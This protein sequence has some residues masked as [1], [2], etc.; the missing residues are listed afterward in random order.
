MTP[1]EKLFDEVLSNALDVLRLGARKRAETLRRLKALEKAL[2][3]KLA[4][5]TVKR[6]ERRKLAT[7]LKNS[8]EII[9]EHFSQIQLQ[10][11]LGDVAKTV[12]EITANTLVIALGEDAAGLPT[13]DYFK[14]VASQ[15]MIQGSP[16]E[17]WWSR[18]AEATRLAFEQQIRQGL[19]SAETNQKIISRIVGSNG[20]GGLM[21]QARYQ[22]S[23]LVQSSVQAVA[24]DARRETFRKNSD[25]IEGLRQVS[26]LDSHTSEICIAYGT[27]GA[28]HRGG[29]WDFEGKPILGTRLP[30]NGGTP[31]HF[32]CRSVEVPILKTFKDLGVNIP[33][34]PVGT[35]ASD[36]GQISR[37]TTFDEFLKRKGQAYQDEVL[38]E[39]KADLWRAGK[40][41]L[42][43]LVSGDGKPLTLTQLRQKAGLD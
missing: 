9:K 16:V 17:S 42:R 14:A 13:E 8:A 39:G 20:V 11:E 3:E 15:A 33:E 36:E 25:I 31:R 2:V 10:L 43:D 40:I 38:G 21:G 32:G 1:D 24:N 28:D 41:T 26:T 29:C 19:A 37:N 22:V 30:Y 12:S 5:E 35:R 18:Q 34:G 4:T 27:D 7:F 23:A 6:S